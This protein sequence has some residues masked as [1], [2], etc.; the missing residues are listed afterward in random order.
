MPGSVIE[1]IAV[2]LA[3]AYVVLATRQHRGC[4]YAAAAS[5]VLY[6]V[7]F[8]DAGLPMQAL[9]NGYYVAMAAYGWYA[10]GAE[11]A[12]GGAT[13]VCTWRPATHALVMGAL[14]LGALVYARVL[15]DARGTWIAYADAW[16]AAGSMVATWMMTR[17]V[18]E[19][20]LYWVLFDLVAALL[21]ASQGLY[22]TTGLFLVYVVLAVRGYLEWR[23]TPVPSGVA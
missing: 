14:A 6:V 2:V 3:L 17:K 8:I 18:L 4:W 16:V 23:R 13:A 12:A 15:P 1:W 10:W 21:Y 5:S 19:N 7:I 22:A 9:L 11:D 20:W